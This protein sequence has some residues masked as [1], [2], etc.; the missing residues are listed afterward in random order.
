[1]LPNPHDAR[2]GQSSSPN[3]VSLDMLDMVS[4]CCAV[5]TL[6]L[7]HAICEINGDFSRWGFKKL[8]WWGYRSEKEVWRYFPPCGSVHQCDR[9]TDRRTNGHKTTANPEL[10]HSVA[11][12][13]KHIKYC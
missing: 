13:K 5:L 11:H 1:M 7:I 4:Y 10:M 8:E 12:S 3:V 2:G 9:R 6:S